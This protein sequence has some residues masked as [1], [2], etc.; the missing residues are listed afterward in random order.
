MISMNGWRNGIKSLVSM[1]I[2]GRT[3]GSTSI[4]FVCST[5]IVIMLAAF[6]TDIGYIAIERYKLSNDADFIARLGVQALS[7]S[8]EECVKTIESSAVDRIRNMNMLDIKISDTNREVSLYVGRKLDYIFLKYF[9]MSEK[10]IKAK[11]TAKLSVATSYKG[12]RPFGIEK[13][14]IEYGKQYFLNYVDIGSSKKSANTNRL[15]PLNLGKGNFKTNIVYGYGIDVKIGD[16]IYALP[17]ADSIS[18]I[19]E[20][21][22]KCKH[23]PPC[24][25][26]SN[27]DNCP[28]KI[29]LPV[30]DKADLIG[31]KGM[32]VLGFTTF[33]V[34]DL[35]TDDNSSFSLKG[36]FLRNTIYTDTSDAAT[37]F[38]LLGI[39]LIH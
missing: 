5:I 9:G 39:K 23:E 35:I 22:S 2:L 21:L 18:S 30:I 27:V 7:K 33:F 13:S 12:I 14:E 26:D 19:K 32:K 25:Y 4:I 8:R 10:E 29:V 15:I 38:G 20:A 36:R 11:V 3:E 31:K 17:N 6:I 37:D 28:K 34:E 24:T 1:R 16:S